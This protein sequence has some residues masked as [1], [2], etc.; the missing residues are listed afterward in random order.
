MSKYQQNKHLDDLI[1][2]PPV[3]FEASK[4]GAASAVT[5]VIGDNS[6]AELDQKILAQIFRRRVVVDAKHVEGMQ[7]MEVCVLGS[8]F[9]EPSGLEPFLVYEYGLAFAHNEL[10]QEDIPYFNHEFLQSMGISMAK[11]RLEILKLA[12]RVDRGGDGGMNPMSKLMVAFKR[13]KKS[14]AKCISLWV[15]REEREDQA[16][17]MVMPK[18]S[19]SHRSGGRRSILKMINKNKSL[20]VKEESLMLTNGD[21]DDD[22]DDD[23]LVVSSPRLESFSSPLVYDMNSKKKL[24]DKNHQ[25]HDGYWTPAIEEIRWDAMFQDLK[26]T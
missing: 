9:L 4:A 12:K 10:E 6:W 21:D 15:R 14:L 20:W 8:A 24:E 11:H 17:L 5:T 26:P 16:V 13:T 18:G 23:S 7:A 3:L 25:D 22:D 2:Q 1:R 19:S